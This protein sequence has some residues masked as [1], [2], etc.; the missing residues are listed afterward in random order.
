MMKWYMSN[1]TLVRDRN[2]NFM[3]TKQNQNRKI[4]GLAATLNAH[5]TVAPELAKRKTNGQVKTISWD[6][7]G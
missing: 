7:L 5:V 2:D 1:A 4:D 3:I 6:E